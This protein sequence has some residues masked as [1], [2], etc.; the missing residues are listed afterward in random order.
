MTIQKWQID[1]FVCFFLLQSVTCSDLRGGN[2]VPGECDRVPVLRLTAAAV[3]RHLV[4]LVGQL[5]LSRPVIGRHARRCRLVIGQ[6]LWRREL[7]LRV[8]LEGGALA[9][10]G[11]LGG[12]ALLAAV[13]QRLHRDVRV[14]GLDP[15]DRS[16][17]N[18]EIKTN[19][20]L[21]FSNTSNFVL[22]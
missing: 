20:Y 18:A 14:P 21:E 6:R 15:T 1:S 7:G 4:Q 5:A 10:A 22:N 9:A 19:M 12:L 11:V 13:V 2:E 17:S 8:A 16:T 3:Q